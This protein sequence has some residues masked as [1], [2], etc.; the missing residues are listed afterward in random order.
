[1]VSNDNFHTCGGIQRSN[2]RRFVRHSVCG[3]YKV[4]CTA[5]LRTSFRGPAFAYTCYYNTIQ[6]WEL[7]FIAVTAIS[8]ASD[9]RL[10]TPRFASTSV[11]R[12]MVTWSK[13]K[14]GTGDEDCD[15]ISDV[16]LYNRNKNC[17]FA[18]ACAS[19]SCNFSVCTT[20]RGLRKR[21]Y[22][23]LKRPGKSGSDG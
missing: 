19:A 14:Q 22:N 5:L 3:K 13:Y 1:M 18:I 12:P 11:S 15:R 21:W 6:R 2:V 17:G 7:V 8:S 23:E 10:L 16:Q 9:S 20:S 4:I